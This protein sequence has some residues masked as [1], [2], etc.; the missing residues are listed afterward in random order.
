[1][2]IKPDPAEPA[3]TPAAAPDA[4]AQNL[5]LVIERLKDIRHLGPQTHFSDLAK[6]ALVCARAALAAVPKYPIPPLGQSLQKSGLEPDWNGYAMAEKKDA[7]QGDAKHLLTGEELARIAYEKFGIVADDMEIMAF[8]AEVRRLDAL[9]AAPAQPD[10][11]RIARF[12][13]AAIAGWPSFDDGTQFLLLTDVQAMMKQ[14][15]IAARQQAADERTAFEAHYREDCGMPEEAEFN[16]ESSFIMAAWDGWQAGRAALAAAPVQPVA[17]PDDAV[18]KKALIAI[19][20]RCHG[21]GI[22]I[23][24]DVEKMAIAAL[25]A[26]AAQ[27]DA[28]KLECCGLTEFCER[29]ACPAQGDAKELTDDEIV[30]AV[31]SVGVDTHPSKFGFLDEQI[32][33]MSVT[34]L[35][36]VIAAIAAKAAS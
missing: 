34:V 14:R 27:G 28:V 4:V 26:P 18:L 3:T 33:G 20:D 23:S 30:Q 16:W 32:Q 15:D 2:S 19:R 8:I 13:R 1:M 11:S 36:Q 24:D 29:A 12:N 5:E 7:A 9:A 17:A 25:A 35:R 31:R 21:I 22:R 6:E 10:I